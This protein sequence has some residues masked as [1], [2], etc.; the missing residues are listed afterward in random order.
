MANILGD[1]ERVKHQDMVPGFV[2]T[3]TILTFILYHLFSFFDIVIV[4]TS[5]E[6]VKWAVLDK[7]K[8]QQQFPSNCSYTKAWQIFLVSPFIA[9]SVV[10]ERR[11]GALR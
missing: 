7:L 10:P 11:S 4:E 3:N 1:L 6:Y 8:L 5:G 9:F 2:W